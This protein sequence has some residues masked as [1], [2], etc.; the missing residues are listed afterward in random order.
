MNKKVKKISAEKAYFLFSKEMHGHRDL[1]FLASLTINGK[2]P[3]DIIETKD[4][5]AGTTVCFTPA[6]QPSVQRWA[7]IKHFQ[8]PAG[9]PLAPAD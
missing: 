8:F 4:V 9:H 1:G 2:V 3:V 6:A 7:L 5:P